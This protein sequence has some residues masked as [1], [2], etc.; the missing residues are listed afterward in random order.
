MIICPHHREKYG[1]R[2]RCGKVRCGV[3]NQLAGHKS[4]TAKGDRGM[5]SRESSFV[6]I[7]TGELHPVGT[8]ICKRCREHVK[9]LIDSTST[10]EPSSDA[11]SLEASSCLMVPS[12]SETEYDTD[13]SESSELESAQEGEMST[14]SEGAEELTMEMECLQI[15][16]ESFVPSS[17]ATSET[18]SSIEIGQSPFELKRQKLNAFLEECQIKA[19]G[20]PWLSW[21]QASAKTRERY[22]ANSSEIVSSVLKVVYPDDPA[23]LWLEL[24]TSTKVNVMLG[25]ETGYHPSERCYLEALAESYNNASSWDTRRQILSCMAGV[26]SYRAIATFIPGLSQ[27]RYTIANL[28]RLH[29]GRAVPV[30]KQPAPR[31]RITNKQLDHFLCFITSPHLVQ[32]LPFGEKNLRL[33]SGQYIE[34]PNIIRTLVPQRIVKQY[35][36]YCSDTGF[37]PF[38]ESTMLRILS[39]CSASVRKS[40]QG[41][42]YF[43]AEGARAF[44]TLSDL[45]QQMLENGAN[46]ERVVGLQEAL[47]AGKLY[48]KCDFK[49]HISDSSPV[50]EHCSSFSLSDSSDPNLR[51]FC[52]H[53]HDEKCDQCATLAITLEDIEKLSLETAFSNEDDRDEG[54]FLCQN[55]KLA[56]QSWKC[57]LMRTVRQDQARLDVLALL[58]ESTVLVVN[59]WAMKFLPQKYRESQSDWFGKRGISWHISVAFRRVNG[60]LQSQGFINVIQSS[61]QESSTVVVILQHVINTLKVDYPEIKRVFLRQDN[62]G[63][64]HSAS[65]VLACPAIEKTT[66]V[67]V[68]RLDFSDPQGGKGAADRLAATAK[69]HIRMYINEGHDV[70]TAQ[71]MQE[72]LLSHGGIE[73]V[74]VFVSHS[75]DD[76]LTCVSEQPKIVGISKLNNFQFQDGKLC[77]WRA[78][79][80]GRGKLIDVTLDTDLDYH[81]LEGSYSTGGFKFVS[82]KTDHKPKDAEVKEETPTE[83]SDSRSAAFPCPQEGCIRVFQHISS[84][85]RHLSLEK[86]AKSLERHSLLDLA[87]IE[88][89]SRL[90]E[91]VSIMPTLTTTSVLQNDVVSIAQEGWSLKES[92]KAYR[93]NEKQK[94]Y[95]EAKFNIGQTSGRKAEPEAVAREM[96]RALD[97]D[98]KR[99]FQ[100]T[101]FLTV[102]QITS[103]FSRLAAKVRKQV[104]PT[105]DDICA[106]QEE[107]NFCEARQEILTSIQ[108]DHPITFDQYNICEM[109]KN[110]T[111]KKLK[112][113]LLQMLCEKFELE[114]P[115]TGQR[116]KA[117][118]IAMLEELVAGCSCGGRSVPD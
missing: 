96:R 6:F 43:A 27:Y 53:S 38:S 46:K 118:Y 9:S 88:Y 56:I 50:A 40:L 24:Q 36:Q 102:T 101:E 95:L 15:G 59:D 18:S 103:F 74:R 3:P 109:V 107:S 111:L 104:V 79:D 70:T 30:P 94:D 26:A 116:K 73:G 57:H 106:A 2:W 25:S 87:K 66:G 63:C 62:A 90:K 21:T 12:T 39:E 29:Y 1:L 82:K 113:G 20:K 114:F 7:E 68:D 4:L 41:L 11:T 81:W 13:H 93:F 64:Y 49:V 14:T 105:E 91:G 42:D 77:A 86:C 58:D 69:S 44:D 52:N 89:A 16:D 31:L 23:S 19:L 22:V 65:T 80:V 67:K 51:L 47:K 71:Q 84:L 37:A 92:K 32:D 45:L 48:L 75:L 28:H 115:S 5:N 100:P 54:L 98:G 10:L 112:L 61:N 55:A 34:V 117:P 83:E 8:P 110:N 33:S 97:S 78:Y 35:K 17:Q 72:A 99:L 60:E 85:E 76:S 108:A